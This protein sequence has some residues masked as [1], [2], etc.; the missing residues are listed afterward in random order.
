MNTP[1]DIQLK[2]GQDLCSMCQM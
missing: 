2:L 1:R